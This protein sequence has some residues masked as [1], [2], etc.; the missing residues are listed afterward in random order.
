M[1]SNK[2]EDFAKTVSFTVK[3]DSAFGFV[4]DFLVSVYETGVKK[5]FFVYYYLNTKVSKDDE[6]PVTVMTLS[7]NLEKVF[8]KFEI[9]DYSVKENGME[10]SCTLS[11]KNYYALIKECTKVLSN[12]GIVSNSVCLQCEREISKEEEKK[13]RISKNFKNHLLCSDCGKDLSE[14]IS[15]ET[16]EEENITNEDTADTKPSCPISEETTHI[17]QTQKTKNSTIKGIL[18]ATLLSLG[19]SAC[20]ILLYAFAIPTSEQ[21]SVFKP[22]YYVNWI[23]ALIAI[24]SFMGYK[25]FSKDT[26]SKNKPILISATV[27][28]II[29]VITQYIS[30]L[31]LYA[32]ESIFIYENVTF[33]IFKKTVPSLLKIPFI[34]KYASPDFK[35]YLMMDIIF[36]II[37]FLII[38]FVLAPKAEN[39]TIIEE[40]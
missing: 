35:I 31:I 6:A 32:R 3:K 30:S 2:I 8:K 40:I 17:T 15:N 34:D 10:V 4:D 38:S 33:E 20:M 36:V 19:F 22:G 28:L 29:T 26:T 39:E 25:L 14:E 5:S 1:I 13:F 37:A 11:F 12:I 9:K 7:Q 16:S 27:S 23:S 18:G 24:A 21:N